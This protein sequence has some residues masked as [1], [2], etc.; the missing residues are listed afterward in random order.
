MPCREVMAVRSEIPT[1]HINAMRGK[2]TE[3]LNVKPGG[4]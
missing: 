2:D 4:T 1:E 3:F